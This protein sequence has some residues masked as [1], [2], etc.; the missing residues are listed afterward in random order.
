MVPQFD[1]P[2]AMRS[3][4]GLAF[5]TKTSQ[6]V[7]AFGIDWKLHCAD[8][9][10]GSG[11]VKKSKQDVKRNS[12]N[13]LIRIWQSGQ[14]SFP[15]YCFDPT[16]LH[17]GRD[18]PPT[19]LHLEDLPQSFPG[20]E[21]NNWQNS[22]ITPFSSHYIPLQSFIKAQLSSERPSCPLRLKPV[23]SLSPPGR[24]CSQR[25][26]GT[27]L[28]RAIHSDSLHSY[29]HEDIWHYAI[30]PPHLGQESGSQQ[31][32]QHSL[33]DYAPIK[34]ED[35]FPTYSLLF[36]T[37]SWVLCFFLRVWVRIMVQSPPP[38]GLNLGT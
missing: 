5:I 23:S 1:L 8:S 19:K 7:N 16:A 35:L 14:T 10:Q 28:E 15:L 21:T 25:R 20:S 17:I 32:H 4:K 11:E 29:S 12:N 6:W 33:P 18:L 37:S 38:S 13:I 3:N 30:D 22:L 34:I 27:N 26:A 2:L 31:H 9:P 36:S 24:A